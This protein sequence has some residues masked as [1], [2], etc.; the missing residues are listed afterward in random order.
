MARI[1]QFTRTVLLDRSNPGNI[2]AAAAAN[3]GNQA[4]G[5]LQQADQSFRNARQ[6][7][8]LLDEHMQ[9]KEAEGRLNA[10]KRFNEFQRTR[11]KAQQEDQLARQAEPTGFTDQFDEWHKTQMADF[12]SKLNEEGSSDSFDLDYYRQLMDRD[13]T[14]AYDANTN[15]ETGQRI[16][17]TFTGTEQSIEG[18]NVNF[19]M[20]NPGWRGFVK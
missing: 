20:S 9:Q 15:W 12:E 1:P 19:M 8:A 2:D 3:G 13:R 5:L 17:N 16:K 18:M 6:A 11:I 4:R 10:Q 14:Q 7:N